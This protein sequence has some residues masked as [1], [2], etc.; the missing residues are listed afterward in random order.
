MVIHVHSDVS[1][2]TESQSR[3]RD[4]GRFFLVY[5]NYNPS[6]N[7]G[8]ILTISHITKNVMTSSSEAEYAAL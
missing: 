3:I 5:Q 7:N 1:S 6:D 8:T 2:Q 4:G